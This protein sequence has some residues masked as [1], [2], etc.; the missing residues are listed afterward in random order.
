MIWYRGL[1]SSNRGERWFLNKSNY[2]LKIWVWNLGGNTK[3][4][5]NQ[6]GDVENRG[7]NLGTTVQMA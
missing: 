7:G 2:F 3:N 1:C 5:G 4:A 6:G